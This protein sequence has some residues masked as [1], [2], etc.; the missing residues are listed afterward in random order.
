MQN[1]TELFSRIQSYLLTKSREKNLDA[2]LRNDIISQL[3][4][5][6]RLQFFE[7]VIPR[8]KDI[9]ADSEESEESEGESKWAWEQLTRVAVPFLLRVVAENEE[10]EKEEKEEEEQQGKGENGEVEK[11]MLERAAK[12]ITLFCGREATG[13]LSRTWRFPREQGES[14]PVL[15]HETNFEDTDHLGFTTWNSAPLLAR[16]ISQR[17]LL[18]NPAD[19]RILELG[20]GTGLLG[21]VCAKMGAGKVV[22]TDFHARVLENA[23]HNVRENQC[24]ANAEVR[25][26]DWRKYAEENEL[27]MFDVVLAADVVYE[28]EHARL[29]PH[30]IRKHLKKA[31]GVCLMC[32]PRR[33]GYSQEL[34]LF[35]R[36][37]ENG[38]FRLVKKELERG[39]GADKDGEY[40]VYEYQP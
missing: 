15:I 40:Q 39:F 7:T 14:L 13:A 25:R 26:L 21:I 37:M 6:C 33:R 27:G 19:L 12:L 28:A 4:E 20:T 34:E 16:R 10:E 11:D 36:E 5:K 24:E 8:L 32:L 23:A 3:E 17:L 31:K 9:S 29:L 1:D 18:P 22:L 35:E 30:V 2:L 38:G